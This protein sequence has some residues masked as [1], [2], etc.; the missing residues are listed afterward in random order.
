MKNVLS[1]LIVAA[2]VTAFALPALAQDAAGA[3][4]AQA[5]PCSEADAM[6]AMYQKFLAGYKGTPDQQKVAADT[7]REYLSKYGNCPDESSKKIASFVQGWVTK[8]DK[9]VR[10]F[11]CTDAFNKK[12]YAGAFQACQAIL[13]EQPDNTE[14]VLM[15]ARAGYANV[16]A[17][18]PNKS[19]N[20]DSARMARRAVELIQSG[21]APA[22]WDPFANQ[23]E[24]LGFL[25]YSQGV[26]AQETDPTAAAASFIK[27]AQSNSIFKNESST[28][29]YLAAI[30]EAN[31]LKKLVDAYVAAF[32]PG[33]PIP[34]EKKAQYDEMVLHISKVQDRIID[35]YARA[36]A[37]LKAD[38]KADAARTKA[39]L[40]KLTAYYKVR[41]E[42]KE[43]GLQELIANVLSK[44]IMLPGQETTTLPAPANSSAVTGTD[45]AVKPAA[46]TSANGTKPAAGAP[47]NGAKPAATAPATTPASGTK[48]APK[49]QS[50]STTKPAA[51]SAAATSGH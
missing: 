15:L 2:F 3:A 22:K 30:Y 11:A 14:I 41:H 33:V 7:G 20:A 18:T 10:D 50:K 38:P 44:P 46:T 51:K 19:L 28:Y 34:D 4:P 37:V 8:Y 47:A 39:V 25:Y 12:N 31:E 48:P 13:N 40:A 6:A 1:V 32:P 16:T 24:A 49:P 9:A 45:G 36:Y 26:F 29:T 35:A 23:D 27:A 17:P 42:D 43:E 21:K 5:G